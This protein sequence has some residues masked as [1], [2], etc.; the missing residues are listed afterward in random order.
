[1]NL[2]LEAALDTWQLRDRPSRRLAGDVSHREYHRL[3]LDHGTVVAMV[4]PLDESAKLRDW[5]AVGAWLER[6]GV[7]VPRVR[8]LDAERGVLLIDDVGD[9]LLTMVPPGEAERWYHD[10]IETLARLELAAASERPEASPAHGRDLTEERIRWELRRFRKV[11]AGLVRDLDDAD[12]AAWKD[13]EDRMVAALRSAP[14]V[15]MHRDLHARN[16]LVHDDR[17]YWIDFQD[18][19]FGPWLYDLTSLLF[20]PYAALPDDRRAAFREHYLAL[21]KRVCRDI[22]AEAIEALWRVC[23]VQR[24]VHC[25]ACYVWVAEHGGRPTYLPYLPFALRH[26]REVM[27]AC[28]A[29]APLAEVMASRW[30]LAGERWSRHAVAH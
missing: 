22:D 6:H 19:M 30:E 25:V 15:W 13:G 23:A 18:A 3:F 1:M 17:L 2:W 16:L 12:L 26:L 5:L 9:T 27:E 24:L 11:V 8:A 29:A 20:D 21:T 28:P 7:A 10:A 14:Q 4:T